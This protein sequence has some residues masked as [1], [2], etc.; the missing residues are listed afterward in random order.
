MIV[1]GGIAARAGPILGAL[2]VVGLPAIF[3]DNELVPLLTSSI[4][5]LLVL[6]YFPGGLA[7][8]GYLVRN[9]VD[10]WAVRRLPPAVQEVAERPAVAALAS[11]RIAE[12]RNDAADL[13]H[14]V[15]RAE[16]IV[17][18]FGGNVA[19]SDATVRVSRGEIVGLIGANGA[20]KSTLLNAIGG[21]VPARGSVELLGRDISSLGVT[22]RAQRGLGR[23]FQTALLFPELSVRETIQ[24]ALE[25]RG[26]TPFVATALALP[27][28]R[29]HERARRADA[30][31]LISFLGLGRYAD[32][33]VIDLSTG[34]RR[35]VEIANLLALDA[36]VLCLDEPTSGLAQRETEKFGPL[37]VSI[38]EEMSASMIIIEHDM[39][40]I[41]AMS[42]RVYCLEL[43]AVIAEGTPSEVR[44]DPLVIASYLGTDERAI[45]RSDAA[46]SD[47]ARAASR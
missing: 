30:D 33:Y 26:R 35:I 42:D 22:A 12:A 5:L 32:S 9:A 15:L 44:N 18:R 34:T 38:R 4:G 7:Q 1:I 43:G 11:P 31:E 23:T 41:M 40:L 29:R 21:Y 16:H 8:I 2:W 45:Q 24:V 3:P 47:A 13:V 36:R 14:E 17:V 37:L 6:M 10:D 25:A 28:A 27:A 46:P 39:P 19:V 20:G